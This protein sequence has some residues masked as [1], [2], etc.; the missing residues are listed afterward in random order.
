MIIEI[1]GKQFKKSSHSGGS[2]CVGVAFE[3]EKIHVINTKEKQTVVVFNR[4][5]WLAFI[6]GAKDGEFDI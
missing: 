3:N 2:S 1:K 4:E 6:R 5:E